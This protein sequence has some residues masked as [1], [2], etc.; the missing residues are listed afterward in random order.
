MKKKNRKAAVDD[1]LRLED[2]FQLVLAKKKEIAEKNHDRKKIDEKKLKEEV[3]KDA[4]A[5]LGYT[6]YMDCFRSIL[7]Q[8]AELL[9]IKNF[10]NVPEDKSEREMYQSALASVGLKMDRKKVQGEEPKPS[11]AEIYKKLLSAS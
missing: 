11:A 2:K 9:Y 10:V 7:A 3:R 8:A 1:F 4:L 6:S 5:K